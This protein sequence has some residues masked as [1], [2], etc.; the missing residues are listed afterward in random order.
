M[1]MG[2]GLKRLAKL[3]ALMEQKNALEVRAAAMAVHEA[4]QAAQSLVAHRRVELSAARAGLANGSRIEALAAEHARGAYLIHGNHLRKLS[5]ELRIAREQA[6]DNHRTSRVERRQ[7]DGVV[8]RAK[9]VERTEA[10]RREQGT[11]DDR[12]AARRQW[13]RERQLELGFKVSGG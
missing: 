11:S 7:I 13:T 2:A 3:Y 1:A 12:F 10:D 6:A 9:V 4:E 8:E 5:D